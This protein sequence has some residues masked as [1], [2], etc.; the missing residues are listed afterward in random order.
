MEKDQKLFWLQN[1]EEQKDYSISHYVDWHKA[2]N[3]EKIKLSL[4]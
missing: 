4:C 3:S 2:D 1:S